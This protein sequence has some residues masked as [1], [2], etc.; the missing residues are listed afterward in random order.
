MKKDGTVQMTGSFNMSG[1]KIINLEDPTSDNDV[2]NKKYVDKH[3]LSSQV[4][5]SHH[6][7]EFSYLMKSTAEWTDEITTATSFYMTKIADLA[8]NKGN[9]HDYNHKV[10]YTE[11]VKKFARWI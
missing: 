3:L 1:H 5:P 6:K 7:D 2:V 4:Q 11:I 10:I 8:P 9:F